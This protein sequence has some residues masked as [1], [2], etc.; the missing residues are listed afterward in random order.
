MLL[1]AKASGQTVKVY[2][3]TNC[4]VW[5]YAEMQGLVIN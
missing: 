3:T 5:G 2:V 4:H 1:S